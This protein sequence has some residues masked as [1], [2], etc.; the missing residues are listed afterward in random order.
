MATAPTKPIVIRLVCRS[1]PATPATEED[2]EIGIQD[3]AQNIHIG[4]PAK[5]GSVHFECAIEVKV[6]ASTLDFRGP[7][8][9]GTPQSRF[10]YLSWKRSS[11]GAAPWY[12]RV[13]IPLAGIAK[14]TITSLKSNEVLLA[15]ITGRRPHATEPIL[16]KCSAASEA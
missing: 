16:W 8:A 13:K 6:D 4:R 2:L 5:D 1:M 11:G 15:D 14:K 9:H 7:F 3:K 12:W 10:V